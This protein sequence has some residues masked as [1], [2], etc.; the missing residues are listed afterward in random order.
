LPLFDTLLEKA[1]GVAHR[2]R[3]G[4]EASRATS[5]WASLRTYHESNDDDPVALERSRFIAEVL[6]PELGLRSL[7]E[8]GTNTGRNLAVVKAAHPDI[9]VRG[10]D[11]N[12]RALDHGR[13]RHPEVEFVHQ[14]ANDWRED[15]GAWDAALTMSVLDHV[16]DDAVERLA[17][18]MA[19]SARH[20]ICFELFD[21]GSGERGLYKYSRDSKALFERVG[22]RTVRW[23]QAPGQ[24]DAG[25]SLLWLYVGATG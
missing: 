4:D 17:Q 22:A 19:R 7:L 23:E 12:E 1:H 9:R 5:Y 21:G 20:V 16:P 13:A 6:V 25:Q 14:D 15:A 2:F 11:V 3:R 18:N 8:V 10:I 24:Y